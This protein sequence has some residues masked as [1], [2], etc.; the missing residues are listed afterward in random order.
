MTFDSQ[1]HIVLKIPNWMQH[2][3]E[4]RGLMMKTLKE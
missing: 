1:T 4:T 2:T 3:Q